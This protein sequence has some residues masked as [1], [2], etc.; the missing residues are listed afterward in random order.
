MALSIRVLRICQSFDV[1][2]FANA[3]ASGD[4]VTC[5]V[6]SPSKSQSCAEQSRACQHPILILRTHRKMYEGAARIMHE[7]VDPWKNEFV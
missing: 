6:L 3:W 7:S 4:W 2:L 5:P 1:D